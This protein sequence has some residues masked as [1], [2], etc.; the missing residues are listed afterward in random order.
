MAELHELRET[1]PAGTVVELALNGYLGVLER[2][3]IA[4]TGDGIIVR[5]MYDGTETC[6]TEEKLLEY[7]VTST[8]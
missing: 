2:G 4:Y 7:R 3:P 1:I 5:C 6:I 8:V